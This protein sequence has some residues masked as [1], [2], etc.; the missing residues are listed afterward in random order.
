MLARLIE[1][2][3]ETANRCVDRGRFRPTW[4]RSGGGRNSGATM[5]TQPADPTHAA[6]ALHATE[7]DGDHVAAAATRV[8]SLRAEMAQGTP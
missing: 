2:P 8:Y 7:G 6:G 3:D 5:A 4:R 1:P